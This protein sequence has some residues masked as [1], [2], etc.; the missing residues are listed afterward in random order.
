MSNIFK[1]LNQGREMWVIKNKPRVFKGLTGTLYAF[2]WTTW[3]IYPAYEQAELEREA[4]RKTPRQH[5]W[6]AGW[7]K[8]IL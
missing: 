2:P 4:K 7:K 1:R 5:Q 6:D 8:S 3:K